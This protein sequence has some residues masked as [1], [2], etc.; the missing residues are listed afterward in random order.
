MKNLKKTLEDISKTKEQ[1]SVR[2]KKPVTKEKKYK[3]Q[4]CFQNN[5]ASIEITL[6]SETVEVIE[7]CT[8]CCNPN[9]ISYTIENEKVVYFEVVKTY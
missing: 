1:Y 3:C 6:S 7:D 4:S 2:Y 5:S 9:S 8:V